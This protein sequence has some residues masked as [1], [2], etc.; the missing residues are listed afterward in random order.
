MVP[1]LTAHLVICV[2][3]FWLLRRFGASPWVSLGTALFIAFYGA[4]AEDTLWAF[5]IGFVGSVMFGLLAIAAI[6]L[7]P[8]VAGHGRRAGY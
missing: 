2:V 5:Q 7:L 8:G 1:V 3:L 6:D 4:G